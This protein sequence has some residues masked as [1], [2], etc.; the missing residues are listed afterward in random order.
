MNI[1]IN[2]KTFDVAPNQ[3][4]RY[5]EF[6]NSGEWEASTFNAIDRFLDE[7]DVA[8][9]IG[10]W[11]G[12]I[13]F[14]MANSCKE[15]HAIEPDPSIYPDLES[16][17]KLNPK[18]MV[19]P[20]Q[21]AI[22]DQSMTKTLFARTHYGQSSSS[23]LE[24]YNDRLSSI[25]IE[26]KV[27][28][29]FIKDENLKQI[30][31]IKIDTEGG[32]FIFL[33]NWAST[34]EELNYPTLLI[35]FHL[36]QLKENVYLKKLKIKWLSKILLKMAKQWSLPFFHKAI[37]NEIIAAL[38]TLKGYS[39]IYDLSGKPIKYSS[40]IK[41]AEAIGNHSYIFSNRKWNG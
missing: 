15:V 24:R 32:E 22:A 13:S 10:A 29:D 28:N 3:H 7:R 16:N 39:Y 33:K 17:C 37:S 18:L 30:D 5:W 25:K 19:K 12:P 38:N 9:D 35:S 23:L 27:I 26:T 34:L 31:F 41:Q 36:N 6:I 11:A 1:C 21:L 4:R 14:Y 20:Y 2:G 40:L 8:L